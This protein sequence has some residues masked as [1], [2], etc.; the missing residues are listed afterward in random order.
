MKHDLTKAIAILKLNEGLGDGDKHTPGLQ[1]YMCS[2]GKWTVGY[3]RVLTD[4]GR[5][6]EGKRD[7]ARA[8]E[9]YGQKWPNGLTQE[10]AE[11]MLE[12]DVLKLYAMIVKRLVHPLTSPQM[13]A[14]LS[15][16]YNVGFGALLGSTMWR[17]INAK[18]PADEI[19][20]QFL[21]WDK[22]V[23]PQTKEKVVDPGIKNRRRREQALFL[24]PESMEAAA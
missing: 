18:R 5:Q 6:L 17:L 10:E 12:E 11:T 1:P 3:G 22:I 2:A 24:E 4:G 21:R 14:V 20:F 19:G 8:M 16:T 13:C 23:D 7:K 9:I 15:F